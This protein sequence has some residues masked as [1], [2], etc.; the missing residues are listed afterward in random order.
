M[1][2]GYFKILNAQS[3]PKCFCFAGYLA[4]LRKK[5]PPQKIQPLCLLRDGR[6]I[7]ASC[8][9][10]KEVRTCCAQ[11][12]KLLVQRAN[13]R[14]AHSPVRRWSS[15]S[16]ET[17]PRRETRRTWTA[18]K[19]SQR[20]WSCRLAD[21]PIWSGRSGYRADRGRRVIRQT[22]WTL[23]EKSSPHLQLREMRTQKWL[24]ATSAAS[25][26]LMM[27]WSTW[28]KSWWVLFY[29][30]QRSILL[31]KSDCMVNF[32]LSNDNDL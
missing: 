15:K 32:T 27:L 31:K 16:L 2:S 12:A 9:H 24:C 21:H 20:S 6:A 4:P 23:E 3:L 7:T 1:I 30:P 8:L 25:T 10:I 19:R 28:G 26:P 18:W 17:S 29:F 11:I 13:S 22:A 5:K 14:R